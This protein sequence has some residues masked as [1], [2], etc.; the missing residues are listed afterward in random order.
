M[1]LSK[2][3]LRFSSPGFLAVWALNVPKYIRAS[4]NISSPGNFNLS[5]KQCHWG[6]RVSQIGHVGDFLTLPVEHKLLLYF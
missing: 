3:C 2:N 6:Q 1:M 5:W 4:L